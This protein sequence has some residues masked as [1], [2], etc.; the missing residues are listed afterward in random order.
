MILLVC[1][2]RQT[3]YW[4]DDST[5]WTRSLDCTANNHIAHLHLGLDYYARGDL[6]TAVKEYEESLRLFPGFPPARFDLACA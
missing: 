4:R 3:A 6:H 2:A 1:A 5:L